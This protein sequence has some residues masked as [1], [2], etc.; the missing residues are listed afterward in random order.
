MDS[1][2]S[3]RSRNVAQQ[4]GADSGITLTDVRVSGFRSL[5]NIEVGLADLTV[6][7]GAN[8]SGKTSFLDALYAAVGAGR[9]TL[10]QDD[11]HLAREESA[12]PQSRQAVIDIRIR[13]VGGEGEITDSFPQGSFWTALWGTGIS[14]DDVTS[15]EFMAF[16]TSLKWSTTKAEYVVE[17]KCLKEWRPFE[18]WLDTPLHDRML[19]AAQIEP[20]ALHYIDAKRD[21]DDDLRRQ[22]SFWRKMTEDL[23]LS[24]ADVAEMETTLAGMNQQIVDKSEKLKQIRASLSGLQTVV[25]PESIGIGITPVA[26]RIRD[27]AKTMNV[28]ITTAGA[29]SFP[30]ARHGMGTRSLASLLVFRAF[31]SWRSPSGGASGDKVHSILALEEPESHLHPQAQRSLF[32]HIKSI[33]GQRIVSTHSPYFAGQ[34]QLEDLRLFLKKNGETRVT[35]LDLSTLSKADD[36]RKLQDTVIASRGDI[37]FSRAIVLFEGQTE[38]LALPIWA[39]K[40]WGAS[41]HELGLSFVRVN[42][43]DYYPYIWLARTL[44]MPWYVIADGEAQPIAELNQALNKAGEASIGAT[45]NVIVLPNGNCFESQLLEEGYQ[46]EVEKALDEAM[47]ES[48]YLTRYIGLREGQNLP[49]NKGVRSYRTAGGRG[50]AALDAMKEDK[51]KVAKPL[52]RVI[53]ELNDRARRFPAHILRLFEKLS[54]DH[55]ISK[56]KE[57]CQ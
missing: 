33:T 6:L 11:I 45:N 13:P 56:A 50:R 42:G 48:D 29:Q 49:K 43:T 31:A 17:R 57:G 8:N 1:N 25:S 28:S 15:S 12:P 5:A 3:A 26:A 21:L 16:R 55:G 52:A 23:G 41:V 39:E 44:E 51:T 18:R 40:Y 30:L 22:G 36:K 53:S 38:E 32:A 24:P 20:V 47:G 34:A 2:V 37:L 27:L 46:A 35:K 14:L 19:T 10:G 54:V 7:I 4:M 9:R